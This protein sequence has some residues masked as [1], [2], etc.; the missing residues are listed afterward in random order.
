LI[1]NI[2]NQNDAFRTFYNAQK[3]EISNL[4]N[5]IASLLLNLLDNRTRAI[6]LNKKLKEI[7]YE[8][9]IVKSIKDFEK[10]I[11]DLKKEALL[12]PEES[13]KH[14]ELTKKVE[15]L[16][17]QKKGLQVQ[18]E[19]T[20]KIQNELNAQKTKLCGEPS[21]T[22]NPLKGSLETILDNYIN[23]QIKY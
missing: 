5:D 14:T 19:V 7:G 8:D 4:S 11:D 12:S 1:I 6:A 18:I 22:L 21:G 10:R 9:A 3:E 16:E 2:L 20:R 13:T 23:L 15:G 17:S